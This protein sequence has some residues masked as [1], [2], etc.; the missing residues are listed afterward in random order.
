L[1]IRSRWLN[2]AAAFSAVAVCRLLFW[3]CRKKFM[4]DILEQKMD[5]TV[6]DESFVLCVWHDALLL[7]TF[8]APL[9][10]RKRC[11]CLVSQHQDGSYLADAMAWLNYT[12]VR[13][14]SKRGGAEALRELVNDTAG[15]HII[16]TPD[17]PRGPRRTMK[18]GAA[19]V[20]SQT[21]RRLLPGAFV[22]KNGIRLRGSWT[23]LL[24]PF[25]FTTIYIM[26]GEPV[27]IPQGLTRSELG[28]YVAAAQRG[29]DTLNEEADRMVNSKQ[30]PSTAFR[31]RAA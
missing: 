14:S 30:P 19:F 16:V 3:T 7:P 31:A 26:T 29:M 1:K 6:D 20:A 27:S 13:G 12:T 4:G 9:W 15:K 21:G 17:G 28:Q 10:L 8:A 25:P 11:C 23:D 18:P 22:V 5:P 24:I 2:K